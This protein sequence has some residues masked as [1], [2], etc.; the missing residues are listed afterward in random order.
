[1]HSTAM[2][3]RIVRTCA[4]V[5]IAALAMPL[6]SL[7]AQGGFEL[8]PFVGA[9]V[10]LSDVMDQND[11][12]VKHQPN[13]V[14]GARATMRGSGRMRF[15]GV[16]AVAGGK[17]TGTQG[18]SEPEVEGRI[19]LASVRALWSLG[20]GNGAAAWHLTTGLGILS[21]GSNAYEP[22]DGTTDIGAVVGIGTRAR[23]G[24]R[25]SLRVDLE[26]NIS[27]AEFELGGASSGSKLQNDLMLSVG[28]VIPLGSR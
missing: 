14:G 7:D 27:S 16:L 19:I 5:V 17:V 25:W 1:M 24:E 15:E 22:L 23:I 28:L 2:S 21:R 9:F 18:S 6:A 11:A 20:A 13:V 8:T 12:Q 4:A 3:G 10:P 26:D